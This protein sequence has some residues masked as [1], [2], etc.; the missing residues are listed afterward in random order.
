M[1]ALRRLLTLVFVL[2]CLVTTAYAQVPR[3]ITFQGLLS[4]NMNIPLP[5]STYTVTFSLYDVTTGSTALWTE[6]QSVNTNDGVFDVILGTINPFMLAFDKQYWL[7]ITLDGQPEFAPRLQLSSVPYAMTANVANNVAPGATGAVLSL[8]GAQGILTIQG[9]GGTTVT[10]VGNMITIESNGDAI[11]ELTSPDGTIAI[12]NP[13]GPSTIVSLADGSVTQAKLAPGLTIPISGNA[14]GDLSGTYPNPTIASGAVDNSKLADNAVTS[15]KIADNAVGT[16]ELADGSVTTPKLA[17]GAVT[18]DK[19]NDGSVTTAKLADGAVATNKIADGAITT[20]KLAAGSVTSDKLAPTG[21]TSGTYGGPNETLIVQVDNAGR[22]VSVQTVLISGITPGGNAGGDLVGTYPNPLIAQSAVTTGKVADFAITTLKLADNAVT[23]AKIAD[24]AITS[25][26]LASTGV[27]TGTYGNATNVAQVTVDAAGRVVN[28]TNVPISGVTPGG[29]A[30]GDLTGTYPNPTIAN[31][32]VTNQKLGDN[33]VSTSKIVDGAVTAGKIADGAIT[34]SKIPDGTIPS[35]KLTPSGVTT[36]TY[37]NSTNVSQVTIDAAGRVTSATNVPIA[38]VP[39]GGGAGGDLTGTY[40]N[41][42]VKAGAIDNAKLADNAVITSKIVDGAVTTVKLADG[43]VTATKIADGAITSSKIADGSLTTSKIASGAVTSDKLAPTGVAVGTYG[44]ST[45]VSQVTIDASGRVTSATNVPISGV[46]PGGNAGGDLAGTYPNPTI[47]AGAI[48]SAKIADGSIT[49]TKIVD[50]AVTSSK[51]SPTGVVV[52]TYGNSTNVSQVTVDAAGRVTSATNVQITG[53]TPGGNAGGDLT[54]T[55]PNPTIVNNAITTAK[56]ADGSVT[57]AKLADGAVTNTKLADGALTTNKISN[58]AVT[59][60]K[61][62]PTGVTVGTYGNSTNVSQVTVDAAGRVTN[63]VNVPISGVLPGGNAGGDLTG[64]Y[65]N[66]TINT[67]AVTTTKIADGAVTSNKLAPTGVT[68]GTYGNSTNVSQVTIDASGRVVNAVNV[69]ISGVAPGGNAGGDLTGSYPNPQIANDAV[70]NSK[71]ADNSVTTQKIADNSVTTEKLVDNAVTTQKIADGS[72]TSDKLSPSGVAVGT[73]GDAMNVSQVTIDASGRVVNA[74]NVPI[75]GTLPG[76]NAGGDLAGTYP[77]PTIANGAVTSSKMSATGVNAGTYG[78]PT[79]V[80]Q[81][82]VDASGRITSATNVALNGVP[83]GGGAGGDLTG[84]YPNPTIA[85]NAVTTTKI[86]DGA[87]TTMKINDGAVTTTKVTDGAIT[88]TKLANTAVT[89]GSYGTGTTVGQ[90]AVDA[91]GRITSASSVTITGAS[92]IG[93]AGGD[94]TGSYPNPTIAANAVSN[95]KLADDA[96]STNK[97]LNNAITSAKMSNTG[98]AA[99]TYGNATTVSQVTVDAAGRVTSATNVAITGVPPSGP[100]GGDLTGTYPNPSIATNA[101]TATKIIDGAVTTTKINDGAV[102]AAKLANTAVVP[103]AYGNATTVSQFTVDAQGRI[104][105]AANVLITGAAP[106]GAAGGDLTGTYP[107]PTIAANAVNTTKIA[108]NAVTNSKIADNAVTNSKVADLA[109][110]NTKIADNSISTAKVVNNAITS[111]KMSNTGVVVGTYG[112]ATNVSQ[113]TVD[114]AGRVTSATNVAITGVPPGGASGGDL[115]GTYPNPTIA[116]NAV[117]TTKINDGA[118]TT[119]KINDGAVTATKLANTAVTAGSYG[120]ATTVGQFT[121]DAQGRITSAANVTI[122]GANPTGA[123]G[124]D[125]TGNYPNPTIAANAVTSTKIADNAITNAKLADNAVGTNEVVNNAITSAKMSNT[126]V[127]AA[128][129]GSA[130]TVP[131]VAVDAAGRITSASSVTITG[132]TPGGTAGGDLTG[133]YPNPVIASGSV[134]NA[135]IS[136]GAV[137]A[138]KLANTAV[139]AGSYGNATTV[140][141]FTVD[142]QGRV[143]TAANVTITG[144]TPGGVAGGDLTGSYPNP[145]ITNTGAAG[146]NILAAINNQGATGTVPIA[147]G[148]TAATSATQ[149]LTNLLPSQA[150]QTGKALVTD[151]T[152]AN[153]QSV[154]TGTGS[155]SQVSFWTGSSAVSGSN[156]LWWDNTNTRLGINDDTPTRKLDVNGDVRLGVNGTTITN[157]IKI[158][159]ANINIP[160]IAGNTTYNLDIVVANAALGSSVIVTPNGEMPHGVFIV[161]SYVNVAGNVR[162]RIYNDLAD[163]DPDAMTFSITVI[164]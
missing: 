28:A 75:T 86:N 157:I 48:T 108:D 8:N 144:V 126:G 56:I 148:G 57:N 97:V 76:G 149:A 115:T 11:K 162:V 25:A 109:I 40:P 140:G 32:A 112:N 34:A 22:V 129:Y 128:T 18:T 45:N 43:A 55:Y 70:T 21:V 78:N 152:N 61:L 99:G 16:T 164:Q 106:I 54:G 143:T 36:G 113:V 131:V 85:T 154:P 134:T 35:S 119:T 93:A 3:T 127:T 20:A 102:T 59:S 90:F 24:G 30:G 31:N 161:Q 80:S 153:W 15:S 125:L 63:A 103:G 41:P 51:L 71:L 62:S 132:T 163:E 19:L 139:T 83:P 26:K 137:T 73:Y 58:G 122:T 146:T 13:N 49:T 124:G 9:A 69:P 4:D 23:T 138:S 27:A 156:N 12:A 95:T 46:T 151:G 38:G 111:A 92:P 120:N 98:V 141:Q 160:Q 10:T 7:G 123:A 136:D 105:S 135:K 2:A 116:T 52:G 5:N 117:T 96:V 91:Q 65:P 142:A 68:T 42:T 50:G 47:A 1:S 107:N 82:T 145:T 64:T 130:T 66:P 155:A 104:T 53:V 79:N 77:D 39:P 74:V 147:R 88:A 158:T 89:P 121:V 72:V 114:A 133:T 33:A 159:T 44:N 84:T 87:V 100:S 81:I 17:N 37:G 60:D 14:G 118:I 110:T 94:L 101:V 29:N 67:N 6:T 150:A